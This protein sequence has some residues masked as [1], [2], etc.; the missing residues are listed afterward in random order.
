MTERVPILIGITGK[1]DLKHQDEAVRRRLRDTF[2]LLDREAPRAPKVLLSGMAEGA[3]LIAADLALARRNWLVAAVLPFAKEAYLDDFTEESRRTLET[4]LA[5]PRVKTCVLPP[6][7]NPTTGAAT[8]VAD[9]SPAGDA[10]SGRR[11]AHYEQLGLWL[12]HNAT[13]LVAVLPEDEQPDKEGG[14]ARVVAYRLSGQPDAV[15][16]AVIRG[17]SA[18]APPLPL[19]SGSL[20]S[21]WQI[22]EPSA[23]P[24]PRASRHP[25]SIRLHRGEESGLGD[26]WSF[27]H[28]LRASL[29]VVHGFEGFAKH[30]GRRSTHPTWQHTGGDAIAMLS[31]THAEIG[32]IQGWHKHILV[33]LSVG[34]AL[35]FWLAVGSYG[36]LE[37]TR[38]GSDFNQWVLAVYLGLVGLAV[39]LHWAIEHKRWQRYAEDYRGV[40]EALRVQR[41]WWCAGL[42][43]PQ[44]QV[45]RYYLV[46]AQRPLLRLRRAVRNVVGWVR[47]C[48][49]PEPISE[50]WQQVCD[51]A[52]PQSWLFE[53]IAYFRLRGRQRKRA[54]TIVHMLSWE[55]F[56]TAQLLAA[57]LFFDTV[58]HQRLSQIAENVMR[59]SG[60]VNGGL[61]FLGAAALIWLLRHL[62]HRTAPP[63]R[64]W[65]AIFA[66]GMAILVGLGAHLLGGHRL[67]ILAVVLFSAAAVA[68]RFVSEK[69]VWE[70]EAHRYEDALT[71]FERAAGELDTVEREEGSAEDK[72]M[73]RRAV[74]AALGRAALDENEYWLRTHRERPMEQA[75]G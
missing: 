6:L 32:R 20:G 65:A 74:I 21:V 2:A 48:A 5:D 57:W 30:S 11:A 67:V 60:A 52:N 29:V 33:W 46:G 55:F 59:W 51:P 53:Q 15:A 70:T 1:R 72:I 66:V 75:V 19:D 73:R 56:F 27:D 45:D 8:T 37:I 36:Y 69:L 13:L 24:A 39:A 17:S 54:V 35:L 71:L 58:T 31:A 22:D 42:S 47:L 49:L 9:L 50:D 14:T 7:T 18:L 44:H 28:R 3:D 68:I 38:D 34:L 12:A 64:R 26:D 43:G 40:N 63:R 23:Q 16:R 62:P 4:L 61:L 10:G 25:F 41:A